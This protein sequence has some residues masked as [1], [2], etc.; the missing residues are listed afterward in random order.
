MQQVIKLWSSKL[1]DMFGIL[2]KSRKLESMSGKTFKALFNFIIAFAL[3]SS[4]FL[5]SF[6]FFLS[7]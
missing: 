3:H 5:F 7:E 2:E 1:H 6:S 4:S